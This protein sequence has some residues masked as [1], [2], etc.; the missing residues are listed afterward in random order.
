MNMPSRL[1]RSINS[2][3]ASTLILEAHQRAQEQEQE[4]KQDQ[5]QHQQIEDSSIRHNVAV[6]LNDCIEQAFYAGPELLAFTTDLHTTTPLPIVGPSP[7]TRLPGHFPGFSHTEAVG[8]CVCMWVVSAARHMRL[9]NWLPCCHTPQ[10]PY[11]PCVSQDIFGR[12]IAL[13]LVSYFN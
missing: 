10:K 2:R 6:R 3:P 4:Q 11:I 8:S 1:T 9:P 12:V 13:D 7:F 5:K